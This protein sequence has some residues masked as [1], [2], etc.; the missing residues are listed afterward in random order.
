MNVFVFPA[1]VHKEDTTYGVVFPDLPGC[2]TVADSQAELAANAAEALTGHLETMMDGGLRLP[3]PSHI[4]G[5]S[6]D[7]ARGDVAIILVSAYAAPGTESA[8]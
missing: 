5:L 6:L 4:E 3:E 7:T 8:A 1:I 2:V